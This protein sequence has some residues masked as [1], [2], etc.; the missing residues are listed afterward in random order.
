MHPVI[1]PICNQ[2]FD[3]DTE[4]YVK[5]NARRYAHAN[6]VQDENKEVIKPV[7]SEEAQER[8]EKQKL[9]DFIN[10]IF[11]KHCN[12]PTIQIEIKRFLKEGYTYSGIRKAL[13]Y[14]Y[15]IKGNSSAAANGHLGIIPHIYDEAS[16]YYYQLYLIEKRNEDKIKGQIKSKEI[17]IKE[18]VTRQKEPHLFELG[19]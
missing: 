10:E 2:K 6:C 19:E 7:V 16:A 14:W 3:R 15:V 8:I 17:V 5:I 12:W 4:A 9:N 1:C 18:P 11:L 13:H